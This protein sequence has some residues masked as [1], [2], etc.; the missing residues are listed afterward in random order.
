MNKRVNKRVSGVT[1]HRLS[2]V[3][4]LADR[5]RN[6]EDSSASLED[7]VLWPGSSSSLLDSESRL[8]RGGAISDASAA[9]TA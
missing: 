6:A 1:I 5:E 8:S 4:T 2:E 3:L 9:G 7:V